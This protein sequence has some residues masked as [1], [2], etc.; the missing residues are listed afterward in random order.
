LRALVM[1]G[2]ASNNCAYEQRLPIGG[3]QV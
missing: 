3:D 1:F 2:A